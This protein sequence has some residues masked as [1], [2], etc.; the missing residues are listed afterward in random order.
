MHLYLNI[1]AEAGIMRLV[2][3][4]VYTDVSST[5]A[6]SISRVEPDIH[7][8]VYMVS[9]PTQPLSEHSERWKPLSDIYLHQRYTNFWKSWEPP[10]NF[11]C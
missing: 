9:H 5:H 4:Y 10:Q 6:G 8:Q 11:R 7:L 2:G 1:T 3:F